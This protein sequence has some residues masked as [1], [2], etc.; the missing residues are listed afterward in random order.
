MALG[1]EPEFDEDPLRCEVVRL[2]GSLDTVEC[3]CV[4]AEVQHERGGLGCVAVAPC[5]LSYGVTQLGW[6]YLA[7][8]ALTE[9]IRSSC[10]YHARRRRGSSRV[11]VRV[12]IER[13][14]RL[15]ALPAD[16]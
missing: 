3:E 5:C 12:W 9:R 11:L 14:R 1:V 16:L 7:S 4:V 13:C 15:G 6:L 2:A 10:R 8:L